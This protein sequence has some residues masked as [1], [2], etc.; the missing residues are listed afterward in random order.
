MLL[1]DTLFQV[2]LLLKLNFQLFIKDFSLNEMI[3][4]LGEILKK[5][6]FFLL[7]SLQLKWKIKLLKVWIIK[8]DTQKIAVFI[9]CD[10]LLNCEY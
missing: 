1:H 5:F 4:S 6:A 9:S 8:D 10:F 2:F 7:L 3:V